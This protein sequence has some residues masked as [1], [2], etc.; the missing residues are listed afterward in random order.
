MQAIAPATLDG[1]SKLA[2]IDVDT[3]QKYVAL[4]LLPQPRLRSGRRT[5]APYHQQHLDRLHFIKRCTDLG[6]SLDAIADLL[7]VKGG[8]RTCGD[9]YTI[10][11]R[12]LEE[13]RARI[14]QLKRI[15]SELAPLVESCPRTGEVR[16]CPIWQALRSQPDPG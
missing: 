15:E 12:Q 7:A 8:M 10:A 2:E 14:A 16:S 6:F 5:S 1:L 4:G 9:I 13:V 3:I 11:A